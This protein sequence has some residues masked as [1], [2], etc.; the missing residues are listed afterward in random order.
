MFKTF[1]NPS[2]GVPLGM[3]WFAWMLAASDMNSHN[4][5]AGDE[6]CL[7]V[8]CV[9]SVQVA[10]LLRVDFMG[11]CENSQVERR[12]DAARKLDEASR[13]HSKEIPRALSLIQLLE[14]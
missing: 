2:T 6:L 11:S 3:L 5:I 8:R 14:F 10:I 12:Y 9:Y 4:S 7:L 1:Q 13:A